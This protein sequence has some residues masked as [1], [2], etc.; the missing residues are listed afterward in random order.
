MGSFWNVNFQLKS[1]RRKKQNNWSNNLCLLP[2]RPKITNTSLELRWFRIANNIRKDFRDIKFKKN[3]KQQRVLINL[4][5]INITTAPKTRET[6]SLPIGSGLFRLTL[7]LNGRHRCN[8]TCMHRPADNTSLSDTDTNR[9]TA[10]KQETKICYSIDHCSKSFPSEDHLTHLKWI[11]I[12]FKSFLACKS[13]IMANIK[14]NCNPLVWI[15]RHWNSD[16]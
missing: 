10:T 15:L 14:W 5:H 2:S 9:S 13:F 12:A 11:Y 7:C 6:W 16:Q 8:F 4:K 1:K 3:H